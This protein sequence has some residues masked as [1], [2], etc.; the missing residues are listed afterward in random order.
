MALAVAGC[1]DYFNPVETR[2]VD[3]S[4]DAASDVPADAAV[5]HGCTADRFVDR[6]APG[7]DRTVTFGTMAAPLEYAP[8]CIT[9]AA[10]Q[11]VT[12][13]GAFSVHP[14]APGENSAARNAGTPGNPIPDVASGASAVVRF[15]AAGTFPYF[16]TQHVA[17][18]MAGVVRV[19]P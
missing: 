17:A 19:R 8:K 13:Q 9:I 12:F 6:T 11:S 15:P 7:A 10:G 16:C 4:N 1:G 14:L 2:R 3:A 18:G 5:F